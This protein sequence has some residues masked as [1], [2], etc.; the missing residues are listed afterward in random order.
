[1]GTSSIQGQWQPWNRSG[2]CAG[3]PVAA[4]SARASSSGV[5]F[6]GLRAAES[7]GFAYFWSHMGEYQGWA[8][9]RGAEG[10]MT[11]RAFIVCSLGGSWWI[12]VSGLSEFE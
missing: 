7:Q 5:I 9:G 2:P 3:P 10:K 11:A 4:A 6:D 8:G 12:R 1:M